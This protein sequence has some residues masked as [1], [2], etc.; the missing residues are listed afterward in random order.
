MQRAT[1]DGEQVDKICSRWSERQ[2]SVSAGGR[3]GNKKMK[4]VGGARDGKNMRH[5]GRMTENKNL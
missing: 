2:K 3:M 5:V 1:E 4:C